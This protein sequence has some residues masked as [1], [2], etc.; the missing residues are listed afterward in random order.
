MGN[1]FYFR[2]IIDSTVKFIIF[3]AGISTI[4]ISFGIVFVLVKDS[5]LFF[6]NVNLLEFLTGKEWTPLF[7]TKKFGILPLVSGTLLTTLIALLVSVPIG[8]LLAIY[9]TEFAPMRIRVILKPFFEFLAAIPTVVYGYFALLWL[10]PV[11]QK[12]IP[13][14][15]SFNALSAGITMGIMIIPY[16]S[17]LIEDVLS[18]VPQSLREASYALGATKMYTTFKVLI[19]AAFSGISAS[20]ILGMSRAI[21]ETMIVAI[22]AGMY[23]QLTFNPLEP[24]QTMT[25]YIVQVA[26][27]DVPYGSL[28]Y[29]TIFAV[30]LCL[31]LITLIFNTLAF[32]LKERIA[33][34]Y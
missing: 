25:A 7:A 6:S 20:Y 14:L 21:G 30:G 34:R 18:A 32:L 26:L 27:G 15:E 19:P 33:Q 24:I 31:F 4:L 11:L 5:L 28:E 13:G 23:P 22:A 17:S 10:T 3:I 16:V 2:K 1:L 9:M 8:T 12:F 29:S